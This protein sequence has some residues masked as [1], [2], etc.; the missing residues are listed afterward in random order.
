M[1]RTRWLVGSRAGEGLPTS[2]W[3]PSQCQH[4]TEAACQIRSGAAHVPV[5]RDRGGSDFIPRKLLKLLGD[6][7]QI[8]K[9]LLQNNKSPTEPGNH[10]V[11]LQPSNL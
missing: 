3:V 9:P 8:Y 6:K 7:S 5:S 4:E 2:E 11:W 10:L 1:V